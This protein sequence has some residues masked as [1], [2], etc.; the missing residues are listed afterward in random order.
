MNVGPAADA[1][2]A[3]FFRAVFAG[4]AVLAGGAGAGFSGASTS[5]G[6]TCGGEKNEKGDGFHGWAVT[7]DFYR[8]GSF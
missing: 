3:A 1:A 2:G 6:K 7:K 5:M 4:A 8:L